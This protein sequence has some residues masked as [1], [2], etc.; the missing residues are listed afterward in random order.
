MRWLD[1]ITDPMDM[2][3]S[4]NNNC[5]DDLPGGMQVASRWHAGTW[6]GIKV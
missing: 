6:L 4:K 1:G 3:L 2:S 5:N